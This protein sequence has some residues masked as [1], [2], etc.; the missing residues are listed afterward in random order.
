MEENRP[1]AAAESEARRMMLL[2]DYA[3]K[4]AAQDM[5][6]QSLRKEK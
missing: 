2:N 5:A 4:A 1:N 3:N 6:E